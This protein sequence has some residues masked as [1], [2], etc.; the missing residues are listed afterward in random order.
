MEGGCLDWRGDVV[1]RHRRDE[2]MLYGTRD[3][4]V[5][6]RTLESVLVLV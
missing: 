1:G 2:E 6:S 5:G 3:L 4:G